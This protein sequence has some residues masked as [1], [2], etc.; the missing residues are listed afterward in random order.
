MGADALLIEIEDVVVPT[1]DA[2][3]AAWRTALGE[4]GIATTERAL[5]AAAGL[6]TAPAIA[7]VLAALGATLDDTGRALAVHHADRLFSERLTAGMVLV[8]GAAGALETLAATA[9]LAVVT[10]AHRADIDFILGL[11]GLASLF[12]VVVTGDDPVAPWPDPAPLRRAVDK[13]ARRRQLRAGR[14]VALAD[15]MPAIRAARAAGVR[16]VAVGT[17]PAHEALAAD[18]LAASIRD[19]TPA[20]VAAVTQA[21]GEPVE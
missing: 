12:E 15:A 14:V 3:R 8:D 11:A 1:R 9:R 4:H 20:L 10:R 6:A 5:D 13:L 2:R 18:A 16:C 21:H 19:I 17:F 7:A